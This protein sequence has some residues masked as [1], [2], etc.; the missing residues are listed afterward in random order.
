MSS[1]RTTN[2]WQFCVWLSLVFTVVCWSFVV[3]LVAA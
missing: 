1:R 3:W 2:A